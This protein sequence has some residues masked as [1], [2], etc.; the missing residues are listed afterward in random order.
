MKNKTQ[1][2]EVLQIMKSLAASYRSENYGDV[3]ETYFARIQTISSAPSESI[4]KAARKIK[5]MGS[6][7]LTEEFLSR[8]IPADYQNRE[9]A[10]H[11]LPR[12]LDH[13]LNFSM[14]DPRD[15]DGKPK[16]A[17]RGGVILHGGKQEGTTNAAFTLL[18]QWIRACH[19]TRFQHHSAYELTRTLKFAFCDAIL[20]RYLEVETEVLFIDDLAATRLCKKSATI[21]FEF[22]TEIV[23]RQKVLVV[24]VDLAGDDLARYW[25][26]LDPSIFSLCR[27]IVDR[28][29]DYSVVIDFKSEGKAA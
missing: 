23:R 28:L 17:F 10:E 5:D 25:S 2:T 29:R 20:A 8:H 3:V 15:E 16:K 26:A 1:N 27:D 7:R 24:T 4:K 22:V 9:S 13:I 14:P 21:L 18:S 11:P 6:K 12:A 19:G